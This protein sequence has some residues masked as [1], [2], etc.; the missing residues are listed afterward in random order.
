MTYH[1]RVA[2]PLVPDRL[3]ALYPTTLLHRRLENM[4]DVNRQLIALIAQIAAGE[5]NA[6]IGTT[7]EGGFQ[8]RDDLFQRDHPALT[9][10]KQHIFKAV[11]DYAAVLVRQECSAPPS[12]V[13]F[14][15]WGWGVV[16]KAGNSQGLHV[17]PNA[18][19]SGVYYVT[20]PPST[21]ERGKDD[22]K[23]SFYD[24]RPRAN[25]NQLAFQIT[26]RREMPTPGDMVLFPSWLEH[27]VSPF[28]GP[29]ERICIAFNA[30]LIMN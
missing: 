1:G 22:G 4:G 11:Q 28:Q 30:R 23:I 7:T 10:L 26:R 21:L 13:E 20:T 18:N 5:A 9:V 8:T 3:V 2:R 6:S 17:H 27:S 14:M 15:L 24:P 19:I 16:L 29:G 25:M 12:N